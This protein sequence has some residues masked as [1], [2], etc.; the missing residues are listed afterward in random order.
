MNK[1]RQHILTPQG[2][3]ILVEGISPAEVDELAKRFH[4]GIGGSEFFQRLAARF[5]ELVTSDD[6]LGQLFAH[7][8]APVHAQRLA[9]HFDRMYGT[10]DL[11]EGWSERFIRAH[12]KQ[13]FSNSDRRRWLELMRQAATDVDAPEP[14][15]S[16]LIA[17]LTNAAGVVLGISRGAAMTRG[18]RFD[19]EGRQVSPV[20]QPDEP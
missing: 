14:W 12:G 6:E 18:V 1:I 19:R 7:L 8:P 15:V 11:L 13:L 9:A 17:T 20:N 3:A 2:K 10:P 16:D 4:T 5:Y